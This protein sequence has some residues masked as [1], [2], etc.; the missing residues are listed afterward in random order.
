MR[1]LKEA[2]LR[3][4]PHPPATDQLK[5]ENES[6]VGLDD[7]FLVEFHRKCAHELAAQ[8][9]DLRSEVVKEAAACVSAL[10]A[11]GGGNLGRYPTIVLDAFAPALLKLLAVPHRA[12]SD[13]G[14]LAAVAA[15]TAWW[16]LYTLNPID[17]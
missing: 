3:P 13:Q 15:F 5:P 9:L 10:T 14:H 17:P 8:L 7:H 16:G 2:L 11:R 1:E 6:E 12:L 4:S